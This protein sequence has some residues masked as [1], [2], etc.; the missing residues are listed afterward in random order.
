MTDP[1]QGATEVY[2]IVR[3][4]AAHRLPNVGEDHKCFRLHGHSYVVEL[5]VQGDVDPHSGMVQDY[6]HIKAAWSPLY[7]ELDHRY[8]NDIPGLE[9]S[10]S[11]ILARFIFDRLKD[12]LPLL[13][14]VVVRETC[15]AGSSY[16]VVQ[17]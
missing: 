6:A 15:T 10:T 3:F 13:N 4:E 5:H 8:L 12:A 11:E 17:P 2:K 7:D 14:R 9:N 16:G 1:R